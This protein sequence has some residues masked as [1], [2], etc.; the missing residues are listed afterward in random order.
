M[1]HSKNN[2][3][4]MLQSKNEN[5]STVFWITAIRTII[6]TSEKLFTEPTFEKNPLR[7]EHLVKNRF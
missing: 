4:N 1:F 5:K 3:L 6:L 7:L 2:K